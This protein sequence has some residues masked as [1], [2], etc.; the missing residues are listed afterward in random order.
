MLKYSTHSFRYIVHNNVQINLIL[1]VPLRIKRVSERY[2]VGMEELFHQ[3]EFSVFVSFI[4]VHFLDRYHL[5]SLG[6]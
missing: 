3:L 2:D 1:L 5:S 4:L 6:H